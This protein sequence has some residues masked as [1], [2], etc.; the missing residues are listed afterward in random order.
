MKKLLLL[1]LCL[2][3]V[4]VAGFAG[5]IKVPF[6]NDGLN[7]TATVYVTSPW[8]FTADGVTFK[9]DEVNPK[10]GQ[11]KCNQYPGA[12]FMLYNTV[13][14]PGAVE[15][16]KLVFK[17]FGDPKT[18]NNLYLNTGDAAITATP[19]TGVKGVWDTDTKTATWTVTTPGQTFFRFDSNKDTGG[20]NTVDYMEITYAEAA[21]PDQP[22]G[23]A[24]S[25]TTAVATMGQPFT[26]PDLTKATTAD[27]T[28][29]SSNEA[30]ATVDA[31]GVVTLVA[32]GETTI[33]ARA[34][35]VAGFEAGEASYVLTVKAAGGGDDP[36]KPAGRQDAMMYFTP[37]ILTVAYGSTFTEPTLSK[38][39]DSPVVYVSKNEAVAK[40]DGVSGKLT[41]TGAGTTMISAMAPANANY[42]AGEAFYILTVER[43]AGSMNFAAATAEATMGETFTAPALDKTTDGEIT[44]T[45]SNQ[46]V[47]TVDAQGNVT[48]V[49]PGETTI[50]ASAAEGNLYTA[51]SASYKL[52][53]KEGLPEGAVVIPMTD[54][55]EIANNVAWTTGNYTF[56]ADK[57]DGTSNP[58][59]H[60]GTG[61]VRLYSTG[62]L[63]IK[64]VDNT[65]IG[66]IIFM[67]ASDAA[68][69]Y[70]TFTPSVGAL[71]PAQAAGDTEINWVGNA[72][73]ITFTVG[74]TADLGTESTKSGQIRIA[75]IILIP[76]EGGDTPTP[77][78]PGEEKTATFDFTKPAE[79]NPAQDIPTEGAAGAVDV[80]DVTFT[81]GDITLKNKKG[82]GST[83]PRLYMKDGVV[84]LRYYAGGTSTI[85][86]TAGNITKIV[87]DTKFASNYEK[88][89]AD[90]GTLANNVW[91]GDAASV[92]FTW[93]KDAAGKYSPA[94]SSITVTYGGEGG[95]TPTPP[96]P[97]EGYDSLADFMAAKPAENS[98]LNAD[99][100]AIYQNGKDLF[101]TSGGAYAMVYG[102]LTTTYN[103]GDVIKA[104]VEGKY[105]EFNGVPEFVPVAST[106]TAGQPGTAVAA[107]AVEI[108]SLTTADFGKYVRLEGVTIAADAEN[109]RS[110][111]A[112]DGTS[113]VTV[114]N[115]WSKSVTVST[116]SDATIYGFIGINQPKD[117]DPVVNIWPV[118][119]EVEGGDNP[120][121]PVPG[122]GS[123]VIFDIDNPGT[124]TGDVNAWT[125]TTTVDGHSFNFNYEK[126]ESVTDL[127]SPVANTYAWRVYKGAKFTID[128]DVNMTKLIITYDDFTTSEGKGYVAEMTLSDGWTGS[129]DGVTYTITGSGNIFTA[130]SSAQQVRIK[131]IVAE[132][133][134]G[135]DTPN[136]PVPAT[137]SV[138]FDFTK[139]ATLTPAQEMPTADA[140]VVV[141]GVTF[142]AGPISCTTVNNGTEDTR[143]PRLYLY[144][145]NSEIRF[146]E[147]NSTTI[148]GDNVTIEKIEFICQ[149]PS[150]FDVSTADCG[151]FANAV[152]TGEAST[153]VF[154][155]HK[156]E[157]SPKTNQI[158]VTYKKKDAID[159]ID[160][161]VDAD[162][163]VEYYTLQGVRIDNPAAGTIVIRRQGRNVSKI[164]VK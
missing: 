163:P 61:A 126:A 50:T 42:L 132:T 67:L 16:V 145:D 33:T 19:S 84:E 77:P 151:T 54:W 88:C 153:V 72:N 144:K 154:T 74:A 36:E 32:A 119:V 75:K 47:A 23:L 95:D 156:G 34:E 128:A 63:N 69:R 3:T 101:V 31:T 7:N 148:T 4:G 158:K 82:T 91:T 115:R 137:E 2:V 118:R 60:P 135:G 43:A 123:Y 85:A 100:T 25:A 37:G 10:S 140:P 125:S 155:W 96:T 57:G 107:Q 15:S 136:P 71:D 5:T 117:S 58:V 73:D 70:T 159:A 12:G 38:A 92:T 18:P 110:F 131:K 93:A 141:D 21:Q 157:Y 105:D 127:I 87:F 89:T 13:A 121:P 62:T 39:T 9:I 76:G 40:V 78:T 65:N 66:Q 161:D 44:W 104:P 139:P 108:S 20:T 79:L 30:V 129:L 111:T 48:L 64:T 120:N 133:G 152:W 28:Y 22:A 8:E 29:S 51:A 81:S 49:A 46:A 59:Y 164:L 14:L 116:G 114:W 162:L 1:L 41:L 103:N 86:S 106:F 6:T 98:T 11:I 149:Y 160:A 27:V 94:A 56:T 143:A 68:L 80:A 147:D 142:T 17:E 150:D 24:F 55:S 134:E 112:T 99:L 83:S 109:E 26:A 146:Y 90:V 35:A 53:V 97:G 113:T 138:T 45:S 122:E 102:E 124:W 52:T 130:Q